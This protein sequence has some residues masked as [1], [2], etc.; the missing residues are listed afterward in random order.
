MPLAM[1]HPGFT[2]VAIVPELFTVWRFSPQP[3]TRWQPSPPSPAAHSMIP[4]DWLAERKRWVLEPIL[5]S[6]YLEWRADDHGCCDTYRSRRCTLRRKVSWK[7]KWETLKRMA[8]D[9][10]C[11]QTMKSCARY[12]RA[13]YQASSLYLNYVVKRSWR[14]RNVAVANLC[15]ADQHTRI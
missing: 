15:F 3:T 11:I 7:L 13:C 5:V 10:G 14:L 12:V 1:C 2:G 4:A 9:V 6:R 8:L